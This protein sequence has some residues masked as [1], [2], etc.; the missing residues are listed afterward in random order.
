PVACQRYFLCWGA[1]TYAADRLGVRCLMAGCCLCQR[2]PCCDC[3]RDLLHHVWVSAGKLSD[4][5]GARSLLRA[6]RF[7]FGLVVG[8][9]TTPACGS[10][11]IREGL[12]QRS[13]P[14]VR[15]AEVLT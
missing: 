6:V 11:L 14:A 4:K 9:V 3:V 13:A 15:Q 7:A 8:P 5:V 2:R 12:K 1:D 10:R